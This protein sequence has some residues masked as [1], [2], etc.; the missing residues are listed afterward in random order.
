M[1]CF[2]VLAH[3][4]FL[5]QTLTAQQCLYD[6]VLGLIISEHIINQKQYINIYILN[7][8]VWVILILALN[9]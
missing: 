6:Y 1:W 2:V 5:V 4:S 3:Y 8:K 9:D 7:C